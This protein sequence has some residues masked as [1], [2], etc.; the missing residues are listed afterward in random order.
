[1]IS[2]YEGLKRKS[3]SLISF[4]LGF[5]S[6]FGLHTF[7]RIF[8]YENVRT[9]R[10]LAYRYRR[11]DDKKKKYEINRNTQIA[12]FFNWLLRAPSF[13]GDCD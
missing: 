5:E 13:L 10:K 11:A 1:M 2:K 3:L 6:F 4:F 7:F 8:V 9:A 12:I